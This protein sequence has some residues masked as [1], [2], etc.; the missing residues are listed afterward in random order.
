MRFNC[1]MNEDFN[2]EN[3]FLEDEQSTSIKIDQLLRDK[4]YMKK[5]QYISPELF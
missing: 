4:Q 3:E 1:I 2:F 5:A